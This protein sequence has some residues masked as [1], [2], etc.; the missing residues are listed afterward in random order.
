[1]SLKAAPRT[2]VV[3][4]ATVLAASGHTQSAGATQE[5]RRE[6]VMLLA[7]DEPTPYVS[8]P[9]EC[10][11]RTAPA[12][13]FKIPHALIALDTGI[14]PDPLSVVTW[15][16][17]PQPFP[18]WERDQTLDSAMKSS[19]VWFFQRTAAS[20]GRDRMRAYLKKLAYAADTFDRDLTVFW[21]NG[22][23]VVSPEEQLRFLERLARY[24]LPVD[25]RHVDSVKTTL[26]MPAGRVTNASGSH[27][28]ALDWPAPLVVRAKTGNT[29]VGG[30]RVS[31]LVGH[32]ETQ[33]RQFVFVS[34]VRAIE[35][36]PGTAGAELATRGLNA[37]G[38]ARR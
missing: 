21:L 8:D 2:L 29:A 32:V 12:S 26:L 28:F 10:A 6:C 33:N 31:W 5:N 22:D 38:P 7:L 18:A 35:E 34:R 15:D 16:G 13:T 20:I 25:R 30:E 4:L 9:A 3:V 11:I 19:V 17:T 36:L 14:V 23:L 1:M 27:D 37:Q 24:R